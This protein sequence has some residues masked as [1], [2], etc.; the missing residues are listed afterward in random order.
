M[1]LIIKQQQSIIEEAGSKTGTDPIPQTCGDYT[2]RDA[3][4]R[5]ETAKIVTSLWSGNLTK[6]TPGE[7]NIFHIHN[8][9][10]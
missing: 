6:Q 5:I 2:W 9:K 10:S 4:N 1:Y 3:R 8:P 7:W